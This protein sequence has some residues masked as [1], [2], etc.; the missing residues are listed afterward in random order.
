VLLLLVLL[1]VV[2]VDLA[3]RFMDILICR[4]SVSKALHC[5]LL[6]IVTGMRIKELK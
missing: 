6:D 2:D 4:K 1:V 5:Y 3:K